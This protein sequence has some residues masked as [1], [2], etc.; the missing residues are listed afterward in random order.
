MDRHRRELT[1][2]L[3][4]GEEGAEHGTWRRLVADPRFR[5]DHRGTPAE[6]TASTYDR[7]R[8]LNREVDP[9]ALAGDP[10]RLA[11]LHE[12]FAPANG[13]LTVVAGIHYNLFLGSLLDH[14]RHEKR[15]LDEFASLER[16][17]TFLCTELGHGN[18]AA[19]LETTAEHDPDSGT[20]TLHTPGP[21][22]QKFMPNTGP[23]GG[24]KSA[25]VAARLLLGGRDHGVFLFLVPLS[26]GRGPLPGVTTRP[27]PVR[28]GSPVDHCLT[29]FDQV[30]LPDT[31]LLTG[32]HGRLDDDGRFTS[33][34]GSRRKRF[35][36]GIGRV[37]TG[38]LCMSASAVGGARAAVAIAV[39]YGGHRHVAGA[40]AG[41]RTPVW[42]HR[43][44][45]G[46]LVDALVTCY[47]M[48]ALHRTAVRRWAE[49]D[50]ADADDTADAERLVAV[51]KGWT[52]WQ[53][54][55]VAIE[56]R[57]RCGAQG[58]LP[59]NGLSVIAADLEGTITAEGDNT[60]LWAK[61]GAELLLAATGRPRPAP[62]R[63]LDDPDHLQ[64][65]L[66]AVEHRFLDRGRTRL[67]GASS[68]GLNRWNA[69]APHALAAVTA[70]AE[71]LAAE[72]LLGWAGRAADPVAAHV[73]RTAHRLFA[74]RRV[75]A[76]SGALLAAGDLDP[77]Q[78]EALPDLVE[79]ALGS[80]AGHA[81]TMVDA[82][83]LPEELLAAW[84]I[85]GPDYQDAFD[86]PEAHWHRS[87]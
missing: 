26:D 15:A 14:D 20:F 5:W 22:A 48:A 74:L 61:A 83:D 73:L 78:V 86:D 58:L 47:A 87:R 24:P 37:T 30:L 54:R 64:S 28:P 52:T 44:H 60:A 66:H 18:D 71:R 62:T 53:A 3:F 25:V 84:P 46:P 82:F 27:L 59:V 79:D 77:E 41:A 72:A 51:T 69:A 19:N 50:P 63:D 35:L 49:H 75:Q 29:S 85:A 65:L 33:S 38:K 36:A 80:L 76:H 68:G 9:R 40:R 31:A 12:W 32:D 70:R 13:S 17:G 56:C 7:L 67:R 42:E 57:E 39:R 34:L 81:R 6:Q 11:A 23:A 45:H 2:L 21:A 16:I 1:R 10:R 55:A 8:L 43:S 4:D